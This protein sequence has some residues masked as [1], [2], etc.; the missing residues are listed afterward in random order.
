MVTSTHENN[1]VEWCCG[2]PHSVHKHLAISRPSRDIIPSG[3]KPEHH[4][5][6]STGSNPYL[7]H[8][9]TETIISSRATRSSGRRSQSPSLSMTPSRTW[10]PLPASHFAGQVSWALSIS[11]SFCFFTTL[12]G[13]Y[14]H[15]QR[16]N[17]HRSSRQTG[18]RV[19]QGCMPNAAKLA[20]TIAKSLIEVLSFISYNPYQSKQQ[21]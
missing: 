20:R 11:C 5:S 1:N 12:R 21:D 18:R 16:G 14:Q 2:H 13:K 6:N 8:G 4:G 19:Q 3:N 9:T 15:R 7:G 17:L 10:Q